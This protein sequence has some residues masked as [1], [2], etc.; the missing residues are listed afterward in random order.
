MFSYKSQM[1][2]QGRQTLLG[3]DFEPHVALPVYRTIPAPNQ[4]PNP[5]A[6]AMSMLLYN[7]GT[8][9]INR[10]PQR[11]RRV[12]SPHSGYLAHLP[13]PPPTYTTTTTTPS[14]KN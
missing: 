9:P 6:S 12:S 7:T 2:P 5:N 3:H 13:M 11:G 8:S 10:P 4:N 1:Q 14:L